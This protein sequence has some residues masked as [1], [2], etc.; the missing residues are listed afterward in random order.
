VVLGRGDKCDVVIPDPEV[1]RLQV[2]LTFDGQRYQV[3]DLSGKG[4]QVAGKLYIYSATAAD[5]TAQRILAVISDAAGAAYDDV[6]LII[7]TVLEL[8]QVVADARQMAG[9]KN[10]IDAYGLGTGNGI[11]GTAG[12]SGKVC[13]FFDTVLGAEPAAAF[14]ALTSSV[15]DMWQHLLARFYHTVTTSG[16]QQTVYKRDN[17]TVLD[18]MTITPT[19]GSVTK[20]RA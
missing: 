14:N 17:T 1:S 11:N 19:G 4:T 8:G 5:V 6:T 12:A 10:G 13:N 18:Q 7:E 3:E 15:A 9:N 16:T 2:A 20:G